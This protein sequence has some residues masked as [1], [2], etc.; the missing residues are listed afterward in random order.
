VG[1]QTGIAVDEVRTA[2]KRLTACGE[3]LRDEVNVHLADLDLPPD[4]FPV[5]TRLRYTYQEVSAG[6]GAVCRAAEQALTGVG[7]SLAAVA[8]FHED[9]DEQV[10]AKLGRQ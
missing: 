3:R 6:V 1:E 5:L 2:A 7:A 10:R 8:S 9:V 4:A